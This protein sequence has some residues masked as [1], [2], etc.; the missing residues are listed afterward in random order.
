MIIVINNETQVEGAVVF[1][2]P[3]GEGFYWVRPVEEP[4]DKKKALGKYNSLEE[5]YQE[6]TNKQEAD[7]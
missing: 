3:L 1:P 5:L 4:F 2:E 6:W 7:S